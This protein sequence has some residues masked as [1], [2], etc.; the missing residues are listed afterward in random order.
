MLCEEDFRR[1][2]GTERLLKK[3]HEWS[4][5][6]GPVRLMEICGTH[7]MA[8]AKCGLRTLLPASI[9][10]VSGPGCPVCVTP[11]G[12]MDGILRL[13][14]R[15]DILLASYGDL[16]RVPG[17]RR[18]DTL[19]RRRAMGAAVHTVYSPMEALDLAVQHPEHQ[20]VFLGVGFETTAPGTAACI[21]EAAERNL[22][23]FS[24]LCLLKQTQPAL[25][26]LIE[27]PDFA[28]NGFLCP[29]HVAAITGSDAFAFLPRE[30]NLPA[31]VSGF[32]AGDLVYSVYRLME[33]L[34]QGKPS[35]ENEYT[36]L[37]R[38][39]GNPAA[40]A[41]MRQV[42]CPSDSLW[43]GLGRI[44]GGG[45]RLRDEFA[46][47]DAA[48]KFDFAPGERTDVPGCA[49]GSVIRGVTQPRECPLFGTACTP[50][51]P[52]G[53]CMVSSEGACAAAYR[54]QI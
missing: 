8:I 40:L 1:P 2:Q 21:L 9:R 38:P 27:A 17:S 50:A 20:V 52:V 35:L 15:S 10:L 18:S 31:V 46:A 33:M 45:L 12:A 37:V 6:T 48:K 34:V 23:N 14:D 43:R 28:V 42:F 30:Y 41:A 29:G 53:P 11:A 47:W 24:V 51:D 5:C 13:S 26:A 39:Q 25:R 7:T 49:C 32:E 44:P 54:Y 3:L 19:L 4:A 16:L 22:S 36:R